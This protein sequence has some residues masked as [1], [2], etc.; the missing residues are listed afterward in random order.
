MPWLDWQVSGGQPAFPGRFYY[1]TT[2][3]PLSWTQGQTSVSLTLNAAENDERYNNHTT[4]QQRIIYAMDGSTY[5]QGSDGGF[6]ANDSGWVG[7][8]AAG[9]VRIP[10]GSGGYLEGIDCQVL[11]DTLLSLLNDP[12]LPGGTNI[13]TYLGES[14]DANLD[15]GSMLRAYA[16]ERMLFNNLNYLRGDPGGTSSQNLFQIVGAYADQIGLEKLQA[17][18]PNA[19]YP[20]LPVSVGLNMAQFPTAGHLVS[21]AKVSPCT[22]Q[23]GPKS[24]SGATGKGNPY[25]KRALGEAAASAARTDTFLGERYRRIARRRGKQRAL[26]A[27]ARSILVVVWQLLSDPNAR[28]IDLGSDFYDKRIN[29]DRRARDLVRHLHALGYRVTLSSAA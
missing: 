22:V 14:Y 6:P 2:P 18:Y 9:G 11:G 4:V 13:K 8:T 25:L 5:E 20:A 19:A 10:A 15:G 7:L 17:L 16:Y 26:V 29:K 28:F 27:V 1:D 3:I 23:S 24:R 12:A 21:W